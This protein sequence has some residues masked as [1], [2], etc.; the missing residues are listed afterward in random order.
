MSIF[1]G[2]AHALGPLVVGSLDF[3]RFVL[4]C[5]SMR[6]CLCR[7]AGF[8]VSVIRPLF[9]TAVISEADAIIFFGAQTVI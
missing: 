7:L 6:L 9:K 3:C 4:F 8:W 5:F 2:L 1:Q